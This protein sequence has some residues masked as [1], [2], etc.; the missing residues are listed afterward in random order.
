M[1]LLEL[2][3]LTEGELSI[4]NLSTVRGILFYGRLCAVIA[5]LILVA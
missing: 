1:D 3:D 4:E 5:P 2:P